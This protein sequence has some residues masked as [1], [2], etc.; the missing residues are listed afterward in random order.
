[1][2]PDR[3]PSGSSDRLRTVSRYVFF[4]FV[5]VAAFFLITEHR[6]HLFGV[7]P[8]LLLAACPLLHFFHHGGHGDADEGSQSGSSDQRSSS[9]TGGTGHQH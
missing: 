8:F 1:M 5:A 7:L 2:Q 3:Q 6:A 4:G 9:N